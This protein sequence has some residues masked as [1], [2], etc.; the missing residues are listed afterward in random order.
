MKKREREELGVQ[1][2]GVQQE[3]ARQQ[4]LLEKGHDSF[5]TE[6]QIRKQSELDLQDTRQQYKQF[7]DDLNHQRK[8]GMKNNNLL[9]G[10]YSTAFLLSMLHVTRQSTVLVCK[11]QGNYAYCIEYILLRLHTQILLF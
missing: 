2:Y 7:V 3:L 1:L 6:S 4:M 10:T 11:V 5:N 8:R 9:I